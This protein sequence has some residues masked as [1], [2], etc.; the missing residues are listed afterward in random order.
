MRNTLS[1]WFTFIARTGEGCVLNALSNTSRCKRKVSFYL[2]YLFLLQNATAQTV[3]PERMQ[4]VY[5]EVK[6]PYKYGLIVTPPENEKKLD[7][8]TVFRK[9]KG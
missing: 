7:C 1:S 4:Q 6:T 2:I 8:P 5:E 3:S 9:G